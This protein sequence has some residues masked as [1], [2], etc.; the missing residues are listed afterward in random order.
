MHFLID[1]E[2]VNQAGLEGTEFLNKDDTVTIFFS[3]SC[4]NIISYRMKDIERSGGK[5]EICKLK[6]TIKNGLDFY[7]ASRVG[8]IFA[9]DRSAR[10]GIISADNGFQ[11]VLDYW[12]PRLEHQG[13]LVKGRTIA[14]SLLGAYGESER[15]CLVNESLELQSLEEVYAKYEE[16]ERIMNSVIDIFIGTEYEE[17]IPKIANI[18]MLGQS[19]MVMYIASLK[20]FGRK[21]GTEIYR[22]IKEM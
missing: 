8:E 13:Q 14:K 16:R 10:V 3:K 2:N 5:F 15:K 18:V 7:I 6:G 21:D 17:C 22:K 4:K 11:A 12:W 20:S 1:Y 19:P 9:L